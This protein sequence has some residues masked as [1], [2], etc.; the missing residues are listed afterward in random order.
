MTQTEFRL[1]DLTIDPRGL[2]PGI[3]KP[4]L[5][6]VLVL[7]TVFGAGGYWAATAPLGGSVVSSGKVVAQGRNV[8]VQNLEGGILSQVHVVEGQ[9]VRQGELLA[10]LDIT[11]S[12]SQLDRSLVEL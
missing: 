2:S 1:T 6:A 7:A 11:A 5:A 3:R 8:V 9:R 12:Q 4:M 10:E